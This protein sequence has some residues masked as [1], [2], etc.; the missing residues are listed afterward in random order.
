MSRHPLCGFVLYVK[1]VAECYLV[2]TSARLLGKKVNLFS[3]TLQNCLKG[4]HTFGL[5]VFHALLNFALSGPRK[6]TGVQ[7]MGTCSLKHTLTDSKERPEYGMWA[8]SLRIY[9]Y[10]AA[11]LDFL[12]CSTE[13]DFN[14][15]LLNWPLSGRACS[16]CDPGAVL[17]CGHQLWVEVHDCAISQVPER[18]LSDLWHYC[19]LVDLQYGNTMEHVKSGEPKFR[20]SLV[21][22]CI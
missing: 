17:L 13:L 16:C 1:V 9:F 14:Q 18:L 15:S 4:P 2:K 5:D 6:L 8:G 20:F 19:R 11:S 7:S 3:E 21:L 22:K 12:G 10:T